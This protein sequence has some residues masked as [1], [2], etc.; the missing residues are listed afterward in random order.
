MKHAVRKNDILVLKGSNS[1][2]L[3]KIYEK[4]HE[5]FAVLQEKRS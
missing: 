5:P 2:N 1:M 3:E 4:M